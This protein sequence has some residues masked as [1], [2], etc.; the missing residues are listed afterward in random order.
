MIIAPLSTPYN[1]YTHV[2][3][4]RLDLDVV[5]TVAHFRL[6]TFAGEPPE[7]PYSGEVLPGNWQEREELN[8]AEV[9]VGTTD[10]AGV[11]TAIDAY[12][13]ERA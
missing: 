11:V 3:L 5:P 6:G 9:P 12:L 2:R 8:T 10:L 4:V 1:G 7:M 13:Q